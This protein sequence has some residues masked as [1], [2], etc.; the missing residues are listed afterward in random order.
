VKKLQTKHS[1]NEDYGIWSHQFISVQLLGHVWLFNPINCCTPGFPVHHQFLDLAQTCVHAV[2]GFSIVNEAEVDV[3][4]ELS[5]FFYD[6]TD[7]GNLI[8]GSS[9][10]SKSSL[11]IWKFL[12]HILLSWSLAWSIFSITFNCV[13]WEQLCGSLNI[14]WHCLS[15]GLQ[16]KL[17]FSSPVATT[18]FSKL[19]GILS[20]ALSQHHL[21]GFES[22]PL[23]LFIVMLPK[24]HLT[25]HSRM[26][27]SRWVITP[28]WLSGSL[29]FLLYSS[30]Y[31]C[32]VFLIFPASLRS[33]PF[34]SFK[35]PL[36]ESERGEWKSW[37]KLNIQKMKIVASGPIISWQ[38][39]GETIEMVRDSILGGSK[40]TADSDFSHGIKRCL[41][42]GRK[43]M[44]NLDSRLKSRDITLPTKVHLVKAMVYPVVMYGCEN[45]TIKKAER[46]KIDAWTVVLEKTA[47]RSN[48]SIQKKINPEYSLEGLMLKLKLQYF[49]HLMQRTDSSEKTLIL[50]KIKAEGYNWGWDGWMKSP[51]RWT[52]VWAISGIWWW[53]GKPGM[54]W[55]MG[56]QRVRHNWVTELNWTYMKCSFGISDF[57]EEISSLSHS[58]VFL[59]LCIGHLGWLSYLSL[60][61]FA[62]LH[63]NGYIFPFLLHLSLPFFS[64][65]FI[66]PPQTTIL[67][68]C[69]SF[70]WVGFDHS[71]LYN[72]MNLHP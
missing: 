2:I 66:R 3:F 72:I 50:G 18:E 49:G 5:C 45:W 8:S 40:I 22:P 53:T 44:S 28:S 32:H 58:I 43:A 14:L 21:L 36:D 30:G 63:S 20:A 23:A 4:L 57:L 65:L 33:I 19:A 35:E 54:V 25:S 6:P 61:F 59:F 47:R 13:R 67:P 12:V 56:S 64:Q 9:A 70:P 17:T 24:A 46:G 41:L 26:S 71:L 15:L 60:L 51:T 69:I 62:T 38:I 27:G 11:N 48:Q 52:W 68:F 39:D 37:L 10:F 34:L 1:K 31:S 42:L 29:R 7:V 55:S 16:W